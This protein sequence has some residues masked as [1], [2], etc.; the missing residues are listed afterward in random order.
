MPLWSLLGAGPPE[1]ESSAASKRQRVP[2]RAG[3]SCKMAASGKAAWETGLGDSQAQPGTL[4]GLNLLPLTRN[5]FGFSC[6]SVGFRT[7]AHMQLKQTSNL[8]FPC[9]PSAVVTGI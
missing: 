7:K 6:L 9:L 1:G 4:T 3:G 5:L 8:Q 2:D